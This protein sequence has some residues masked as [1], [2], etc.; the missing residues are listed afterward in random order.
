MD[1]I[2]CFSQYMHK[3]YGCDCWTWNFDVLICVIGKVVMEL[4]KKLGSQVH[5]N[6]ECRSGFMRRLVGRNLPSGDLLGKLCG[7]HFRCAE[8]ETLVFWE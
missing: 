8:R 3:L 6:F 7:V 1:C 2:I 5:E 4:E